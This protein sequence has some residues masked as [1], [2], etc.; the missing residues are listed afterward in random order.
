V[1]VSQDAKDEADDRVHKEE[2]SKLKA[3]SIACGG[4]SLAPVGP[5]GES[6]DTCFGGVTAASDTSRPTQ[7][8]T[9]TRQAK[10]DPQTNKDGFLDKVRNKE[11]LEKS[12]R[13]SSESS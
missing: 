7:M 11:E 6:Q 3:V 4:L 5:I 2:V 10:P 12:R 9:I 8:G 1:K 13:M